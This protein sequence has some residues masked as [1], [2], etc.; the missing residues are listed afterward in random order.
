MEHFKNLLNFLQ[1]EI[2][3]IRIMLSFELGWILL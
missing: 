1:P 3:L 2:G